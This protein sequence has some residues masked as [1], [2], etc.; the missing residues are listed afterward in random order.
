M[1]DFPKKEKVRQIPNKDELYALGRS[2]QKLVPKTNR[3]KILDAGL[4]VA[5]E[6]NKRLV[7]VVVKKDSPAGPDVS[8]LKPLRVV[9]RKKR[10]RT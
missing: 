6:T 2:A 7:P 9:R 5:E 1:T 10:A 8:T 4:G 3:A